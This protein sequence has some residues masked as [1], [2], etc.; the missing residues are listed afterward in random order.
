MTLFRKLG[1]LWSALIRRRGS[2]HDVRVFL[3]GKYTPL[4]SFERQV[5]R[6]GTTLIMTTK[7]GALSLCYGELVDVQVFVGQR[8]HGGRAKVEEELE[9]GKGQMVKLSCADFRE[10]G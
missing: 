10:F 8:C 6:Y 4:T 3:N 7:P 9:T 5:D 2:D 1:G